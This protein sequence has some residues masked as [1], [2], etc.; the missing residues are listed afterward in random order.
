MCVKCLFRNGL[1]GILTFLVHFVCLLGQIPRHTDRK[2]HRP[3]AYSFYGTLATK[4]MTH[5]LMFTT[6]RPIRRTPIIVV[7][8]LTHM[9]GGRYNI[10]KTGFTPSTE[11]FYPNETITHTHICDFYLMYILRFYPLR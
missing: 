7:L 10:C 11:R 2:T 1:S 4:I 5:V 6:T 3:N 8:T 9:Y